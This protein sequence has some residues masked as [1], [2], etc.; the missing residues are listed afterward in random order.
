MFTLLIEGLIE[1]IRGC[2]IC[3][4]DDFCG[5]GVSRPSVESTQVGQQFLDLLGKADTRTQQLF[6]LMQPLLGT[7]QGQASDIL[8][9][10]AGPFAPAIQA[11]MGQAQGALSQGLT[12]QQ[13]QWN[14][15]GITGTDF[16][17]LTADQER[18]GG[19]QIAQIP[20]QFTQPI[21]QAIFQALTGTPGL[22][23]QGQQGA[24][25]GAGGV[26]GAA[27]QPIRGANAS[28]YAPQIM[29][30]GPTGG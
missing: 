18:Q 1:T 25:S 11:S 27:I 3:G 19:Q 22:A 29:G 15:M 30:T 28:A 4:T 6:D 12:Q 8:S 17:R 14:R 24:L 16:A 9:G 21:L 20:G 5:G 13:E 23:V 7:A 26:A 10:E 2:H